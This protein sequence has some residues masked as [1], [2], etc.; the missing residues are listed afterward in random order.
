MMEAEPMAHLTLQIGAAI[1]VP[2]GTRRPSRRA[3]HA[4][5]WRRRALWEAALLQKQPAAW[6]ASHVLAARVNGAKI[7][8]LKIGRA[9]F[10]M[11]EHV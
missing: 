11:A 3:R 8:G 10:G 9:L 6:P 2:V 5:D 7:G 1:V 4:G